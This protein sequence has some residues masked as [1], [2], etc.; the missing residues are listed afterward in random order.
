MNA[1]SSGPNN[2]ELGHLPS[3]ALGGGSFLGP[4]H[5]LIP[6]CSLF[7]I[8][9][10]TDEENHPTRISSPLIQGHK[11]GHA[12]CILSHSSLGPNLANGVSSD[13]SQAGKFL[14]QFMNHGR[15]ADTSQAE[16]PKLQDPTLCILVSYSDTPSLGL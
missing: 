6:L 16:P 9:C 14:L 12:S 2:L 10:P 7:T 4:P 11:A 15:E 8:F 3:F 5:D 13:F 1:G